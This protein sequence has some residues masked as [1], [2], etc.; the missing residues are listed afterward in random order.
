[1]MSVW[2]YIYKQYIYQAVLFWLRR[3]VYE[4]ICFFGAM[5]FDSG[6]WR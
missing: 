2:A 1:M 4:T 3:N 5:P 6:L